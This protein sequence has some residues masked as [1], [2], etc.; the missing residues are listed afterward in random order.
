M[1]LEKTIVQKDTCTPKFTAALFTI[2]RHGNNLKFI[3]IWIKKMWY[4]YKM[5][6]YSAIKRNEIMSFTATWMDL[7]INILSEMSQRKINII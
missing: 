2:P 3:D 5:E 6:H 1:Y 4:I 7:E